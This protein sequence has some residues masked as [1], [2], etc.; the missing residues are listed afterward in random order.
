MNKN[1]L[2]AIV[3][4][5]G[6]LGLGSVNAQI[7][8][9]H[10]FE[11]DDD[12]NTP[13]ANG[14]KDIS[15]DDMD[16][17]GYIYWNKIYNEDFSLRKTIDIP[18]APSGYVYGNSNLRYV[19]KKL[20][21]QDDKLEFLISFRGN[22]N[23]IFGVYNEDGILL[24]EFTGNDYS[25]RL[26]PKGEYRLTISN[27]YGGTQ[28]I[29]SLPG[30]LSVASSVTKKATELAYKLRPGETATM[31]I[32]DAKGRLIDTKQ[33]DYV[34]NKILLNTTNYSRGVYVYEINGLAKKF[35]VK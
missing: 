6:V 10:T 24:K 5:I 35:T 8:L 4:T 27:E 11:Y 1:V 20:F 9:L 22:N 25:I 14:M 13:S 33:V 15:R 28:E 3:L 2:V 7:N 31:K 32:Y 29:Y 17:S 21:N 18:A 34:F 26:T 23:D 19:S 30:K 16:F 12:G